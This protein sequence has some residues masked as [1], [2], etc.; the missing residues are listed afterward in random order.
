MWAHW[1]G[2]A[3]RPRRWW[4]PGLWSAGGNAE[5]SPASKSPHHPQAGRE[6]RREGGDT[7][8][9]EEIKER[10][11]G[12]DV[13]AVERRWEDRE[14]RGR[15]GDIVRVYQNMAIAV[16]SELRSV[17]PPL[18]S[19]VF[20]AFSA[21]TTVVPTSPFSSF[22]RFASL[23]SSPSSLD[24][25]R[26]PRPVTCHKTPLTWTLTHTKHSYVLNTNINAL[27]SHGHVNANLWMKRMR[28]T[29]AGSMTKIKDIAIYSCV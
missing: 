26:L 15:W 6:E 23:L 16:F 27:L 3:C 10:N 9:K 17:M 4:W 20:P 11:T 14:T 28:M 7:T 19:V 2:P 24:R 22:G 12:E 5:S 29:T 1:P 21:H 8:K 25:L 13:L 18:C